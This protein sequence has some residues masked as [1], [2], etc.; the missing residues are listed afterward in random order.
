MRVP[1]VDQAVRRVPWLRR[2]P[3]A[4]LLLL[5]EVV[6][7]AHDHLVQLEPQERR[8]ILHLVR[9]GHGRLGNLTPSE[10][11][12]LRELVGKAEPRLFAGELADKFSPVKLPRRIVRGRG[13]Q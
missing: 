6:L 5:G 10:R 3:V 7:L 1:L 2:L 8:R 12:E 13:R 11:E 4:K 9:T